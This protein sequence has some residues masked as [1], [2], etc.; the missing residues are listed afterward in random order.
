[1]KVVGRVATFNIIVVIFAWQKVKRAIA[2]SP[3]SELFNLYVLHLLWYR[4]S[5]HAHE[6]V[7]EKKKNKRKKCRRKKEELME[8]NNDVTHWKML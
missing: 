1:M 6:T 3:L 2:L 5:Y 4:N 7:F 8:I